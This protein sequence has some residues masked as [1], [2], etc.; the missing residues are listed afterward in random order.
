MSYVTK[1]A[2][3]DTCPAIAF[4]TTRDGAPGTD[5]WEKLC[6]LIKYQRGII[7]DLLS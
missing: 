7:I 5:D 6:H 3:P 1:R 2:R 4:L